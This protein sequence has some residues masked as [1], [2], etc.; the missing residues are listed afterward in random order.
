MR[1][2][3]GVLFWIAVNTFS[4]APTA[5]FSAEPFFPVADTVLRP[6]P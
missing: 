5:S 3:T 1:N 2:Q 4:L 6:V